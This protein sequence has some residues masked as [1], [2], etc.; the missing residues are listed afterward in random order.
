MENKEKKK[1]SYLGLY[2]VLGVVVVIVIIGLAV[3]LSN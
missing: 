2:I 3:A 1:T